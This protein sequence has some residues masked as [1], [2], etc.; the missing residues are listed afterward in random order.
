[1][2]RN[3]RILAE[4]EV[5]RK[6]PKKW[7]LNI[8]PI[9]LTNEGYEDKIKTIMNKADIDVEGAIQKLKSSLAGEKEIVFAYLHG[10]FVHEDEFHDIDVAVCLT[11]ETARKID[12]VDNEVK[13]SLRLEKVLSLPVDVKV[14]NEAP[15]SFRYHVSRGL[16]L[17]SR[18]DSV[19]EEFLRRTW[20]EYFDFF[21]LSRVYL[22]E[23]TRA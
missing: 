17:L 8:F 9:D 3:V 21:P 4:T 22:E 2:A 5:Y 14:L 1:M 11:Q 19:R 7:L 15:L 23:L 18:D 6:N 16:L 10:S 20:G 12:I 13:L